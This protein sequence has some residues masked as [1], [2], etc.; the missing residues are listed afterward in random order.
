MSTLNVHTLAHVRRDYP[1]WNTRA[2]IRKVDEAGNVLQ[3]EFAYCGEHVRVSP[4]FQKNGTNFRVRPER[5]AKKSRP[6]TTICCTTDPCS[7]SRQSVPWI[8][9]TFPVAISYQP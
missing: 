6:S 4:R 7:A 8:P 2:R 3:G 1:S 5:P 9:C